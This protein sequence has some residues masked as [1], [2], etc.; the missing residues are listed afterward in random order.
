MNNPVVINNYSKM[1]MHRYAA[2]MTK[3]M[4]KNEL[5]EAGIREKQ[6]GYEIV[7]GPHNSQPS[8]SRCSR[9]M[10]SSAQVAVT[11]PL[12]STRTCS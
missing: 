8:S 4:S 5:Y 12:T 10:L 7:S 2:R 1:S 11:M 9:P 6:Y 3:N